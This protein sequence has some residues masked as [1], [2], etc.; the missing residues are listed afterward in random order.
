MSVPTPTPAAARVV[1]L[2][3]AGLRAVALGV[4]AAHLAAALA[5]AAAVL[6]GHAAALALVGTAYLLGLRH[7]LDADHIAVIDSATR[8]LTTRGLPAGAMGLWFSLGHS[9]VVLVATVAGWAGL[10]WLAA[11]AAQSAV[12]A[13]ARVGT[14]SAAVVLSALAVVNG[15]TWWRQLRSAAPVRPGPSGVLTPLLRRLTA[16]GSRASGLFPVGLMMGLGLDTAS[17]VTL[18]V[19]AAGAE[20]SAWSALAA[21]LAFAAG[22]S[23]LDTF[24]G[25]L[26]SQ[27]YGFAAHG[28][29]AARRRYNLTVTGVC[30]SAASVIGALLW[31]GLAADTWPG[32]AALG[33]LGA[34]DTT[35]VGVGLV[36]VLALAWG[37]ALARGRRRPDRRG[38]QV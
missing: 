31:A 32:A 27:A 24:D 14:V 28:S 35:A 1:G 10:R 13:L 7:A 37:V 33:R 11:G 5:L 23:L 3:V 8:R 4:V 19:L 6:A 12:D 9:T 26:M 34:V 16:R 17:S 22:M 20:A 38:P 2:R 15:V 21:P 30:V 36:L 25:V 18:L 29:P